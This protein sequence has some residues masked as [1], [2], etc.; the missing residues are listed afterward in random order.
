MDFVLVTGDDWAAL[1]ADSRKVAEGHDLNCV[2]LPMGT[3]RV[4]VAG[5]VWEEEVAFAEGRYPDTLDE[6]E[7][8]PDGAR[9]V[10]SHV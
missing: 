1:Y 2:Q 6:I 9:R 10:Q 7:A 3:K 5:S 4:D 8:H